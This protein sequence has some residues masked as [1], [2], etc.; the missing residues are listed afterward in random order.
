MYV[1]SKRNFNKAAAKYPQHKRSLA[2]LYQA[3]RLAQC[4]TAEQLRALFPTALSL[5][6]R[7]Q[8]WQLDLGIGLPGLRAVLELDGGRIYVRKIILRDSEQSAA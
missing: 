7:E 2:G 4:Q 1:I 6:S 8:Q 3:L 5:D